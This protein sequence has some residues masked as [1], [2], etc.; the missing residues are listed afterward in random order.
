MPDIRYVCFSDMHFGAG[1]SILTNLLEGSIDTDPT[2][3]SPVLIQLVACLRD[4]IARNETK[5]PPSLVLNGDILELA[6]ATDN[7][8]AMA[9]QRFIELIMPENGEPI[10]DKTIYYIPGNHDHHLWETA[11]ETQYAE[12]IS[13]KKPADVLPEPWHTT[14]LFNPTLLPPTFMSGIIGM[15][16]HLKQSGV[17]V[18]T[19]Y[20]NFGLLKDGKKCVVFTHGHFSES[21]YMLMT[22]LMSM[23]FPKR[24]QPTLI[25]DIEAENF[26]WIDFFWSTMGRSGAAGSDVEVI[27][28]KLADETQIQGLVESFLESVLARRHKHH[29]FDHLE[30]EKLASILSLFLKNVAASERGDTG[31]VLTPEGRAGLQ[32][33]VGGPLTLQI[34]LENNQTMPEELTVVFGHTHKPF[35]EDSHFGSAPYWTSVYNSGG[36]VVDTPTPAP[37]SGGAAILLDEDLN[38]ASLR[39]YNQS[40]NANDYKV[41]VQAAHHDGSPE[42]PLLHRLS[43]IID[44]SQD[45]WKTFSETVAGMIPIYCKSIQT[46][47]NSRAS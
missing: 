9:F 30:A 35:E 19:V 1:N 18:T 36:W 33:Y 40:S 13:K 22:E 4:L 2:K 10:F 16:P 43:S 45:P 44:P 28:D 31:G 5:V 47:I 7:K 17:T 32:S 42:N 37:I 34:L 14:R 38:T 11:R 24:E 41:S 23:F 29:L 6:L 3:P 12:F 25:W 39:M 15:Y 8:A 26:A 21:I 27:Y 20:P 46:H